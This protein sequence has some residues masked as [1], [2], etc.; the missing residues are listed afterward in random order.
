MNSK[1]VI[2]VINEIVFSITLKRVTPDEL[3]A[4]DPERYSYLKGKAYDEDECGVKLEDIRLV[5]TDVNLIPFLDDD[6]CEFA[7][8]K[9]IE[10]MNED[11]SEKTGTIL[12]A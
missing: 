7:T 4:G 11:G 9:A 5:N 8:K 3:A 10:E 12:Q 6:F 2:I 1:S